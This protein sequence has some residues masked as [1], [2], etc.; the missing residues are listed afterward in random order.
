MGTWKH[1]FFLFN[2]ML[3][4]MFSSLS[5]SFSSRVE[6]SKLLDMVLLWFHIAHFLMVLRV[7]EWLKYF[8]VK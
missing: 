4:L 6:V 8:F 7:S 3:P 5:L 1:S 2:K